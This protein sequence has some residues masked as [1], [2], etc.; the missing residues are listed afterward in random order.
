VTTNIGLDQIVDQY[1]SRL[2][3]AL[4][5]LPP[6]R[7]QQLIESISDHISEARLTLSANSEVAVRDIL[8]RVGQPADIA[9]EAL[10]D[11]AI[12]PPVRASGTRRVVVTGVAIF[13]VALFVFGSFLVSRINNTAPRSNFS[14]TT[15]TVTSS[16]FNVTTTTVTSVSRVVP[17]VIGMTL[18]VAEAALQADRLA[19]S[20][21]LVCTKGQ[22]KTGIVSVQYPSPGASARVDTI[23]QLTIRAKSCP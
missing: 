3:L 5:D 21:V 10:A 1:L 18:H 7:R 12:S 23:V 9:A 19:F 20:V 17:N 22:V 8:D 15:S 4:V 16:T 2:E 14:A 6:A 11:Q 13:L